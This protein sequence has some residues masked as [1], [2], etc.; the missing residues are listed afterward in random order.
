[1]EIVRYLERL[2]S[3]ELAF[4]RKREQRDR[5]HF[6]RTVRVLMVICFVIPFVV[7]WFTALEGLDDAF[8]YKRYFLGVTYLLCFAGICVYVSYHYF[9]RKIRKDIKALTKT[10][11]RVHITE[12]KFMPQ[13]SSFFFYLDSPTKLS[14][15]VTEED[16]S[17]MKEGDEVNIEYTTHSKLYLGYF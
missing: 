14:I 13:N 12:K 10:I 3:D 15:E 9:L 2:N 11:E 17:R 7:A 8:S 6:F 5:H 16:F 4:L 1:M